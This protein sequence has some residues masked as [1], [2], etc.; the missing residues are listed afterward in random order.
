MSAQ[1]NSVQ[2]NDLDLP[3]VDWATLDAQ[4]R[5][6]ALRR[7]VQERGEELSAGVARILDQ[8]RADGDASL[9]ALT[10]RY[11]GCE[12]VSL[13]V[14]DVAHVIVQRR[15]ARVEAGDR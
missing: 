13:A 10:R 7:P 3:I 15:D 2:P 4:A 6:A 1:M 9:R 5:R 12:L 14:S 11:D 8:V